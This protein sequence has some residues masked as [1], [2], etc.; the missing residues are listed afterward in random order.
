MDSET[1]HSGYKLNST[2]EKKKMDSDSDVYLT[3]PPASDNED[4]RSHLVNKSKSKEKGKLR[5][6]ERRKSVEEVVIDVSSSESEG[7]EEVQVIPT[8]R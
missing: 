1:E 5:T 4:D 2:R 8:A 6:A 3:P 7:A